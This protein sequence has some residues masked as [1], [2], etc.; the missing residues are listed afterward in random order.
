MK[1]IFGR[2][3][4]QERIGIGGYSEV[5]LAIDLQL[6]RKVVVKISKF[7]NNSKLLL[8]K[9]SFFAEASLISS[10]NHPG[11]P[12]VYDCGIEDDLLYYVMEWAQGTPMSKLKDASIEKLL[13]IFKEATK[14]ISFL[15][16]RNVI[17][18]DIKPSN[19]IILDD[20]DASTGLRVKLIDFG[21]AKTVQSSKVTDSGSIF[22]TINFMSP[23]QMQGGVI[24]MRS[25]LYSFGVTMYHALTDR[26]P[27]SDKNPTKFA[28]Q[29]LNTLPT[30]PSEYNPKAPKKLDLIVLGLLHKD[31]AERI[32]T[33]AEVSKMLSEI[34]LDEPEKANQ[35]FLIGSVP[36]VGRENEFDQ[37][38]KIW[39]LAQN[40]SQMAIISGAYGLGKSR[41]VDEFSSAIQ[42]SAETLL[43]ARGVGQ[44]GSLPL[45]GLKQILFCL[46]HF[47]FDMDV[48]SDE[49][50][51]AVGNIEP[52]YAKSQGYVSPLTTVTVREMTAA[53][54]KLL[55]L[56][57]QRR[58]ITIVLEDASNIDEV[59]LNACLELAADLNNKIF[60]IIT[61]DR[62]PIKNT[63]TFENAYLNVLHKHHIQLEPLSIDSIRRL[64]SHVCQNND[65]PAELC[66]DLT[67]KYNGNPYLILH[68]LQKLTREGNL[69]Y[70]N[71]KISY[72]KSI[73]S[74][75]NVFF[76]EI[77]SGLSEQAIRL[78]NFAATISIPFD[79]N[80]AIDVLNFPKTLAVSALNELVSASMLKSVIVEDGLQKYSVS[81]PLV[82]KKVESTIDDNEKIWLHQ[83]IAKKLENL[84]KKEHG[85]VENVALHYVLAGDL[86]KAI[87]WS[88]K[89][90]IEL[91]K[92]GNENREKYVSYIQEQAK[93]LG[94]SSIGNIADYLRSTQLLY[95]N[96]ISEAH[97]LCQKVIQ[98]SQELNDFE[99]YYDAVLVL[100]GICKKM[101]KYESFL[102]IAKEVVNK[103]ELT[104]FPDKHYEL[105]VLLSSPA[106]RLKDHPDSQKW[107]KTAL[108]FRKS[109]G[110]NEM[111][112]VD[113]MLLV[114][115]ITCSRI[116]EASKFGAEIL[117]TLAASQ[118]TELYS[119]VSIFLAYC[120]YHFGHS[121]NFI[122]TATKH[123]PLIQKPE[124]AVLKILCFS[125]AF[126]V[127]R[128]SGDF[129]FIEKNK[130]EFI[131]LSKAHPNEQSS[132]YGQASLLFAFMFKN[133]WKDVYLEISTF[134]VQNESSDLI[135]R[136]YSKLLFG[137]VLWRQ[138]R[139]RDACN[140]FAK[141][142]EYANST[143]LEVMIN[144]CGQNILS[145]L[146]PGRKYPLLDPILAYFASADVNVSN[147]YVNDL[148]FTYAKGL[149][150]LHKNGKN[151]A[152]FE[153]MM[154]LLN[155]ALEMAIGNEM[156]ALYASICLSLTYA[157][158]QRR[159]SKYASADD[160][161]K[162]QNMLFTA[163][164][165]YNATGADYMAS[166]VQNTKSEF[167]LD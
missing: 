140:L 129:D 119:V 141:A 99:T 163:E 62:A 50:L 4:L 31:P 47:D 142:W 43:R 113:V 123:L 35:V 167:V 18:R 124:N 2:Y 61:T 125:Y 112:S 144:Y 137:A 58:V 133:G 87:E 5:F 49:L 72:S 22:G 64:L 41:F 153:L 23:E 19:F 165:I 114:N 100:F 24:D 48:K 136:I 29:L 75:S 148:Y 74:G 76:S 55:S 109:R 101:E 84:A 146:V 88:K 7:Q 135:S 26:L 103:Q 164:F 147:Y 118:N 6:D 71:G 53:F 36:M 63:S 12:K 131:E 138:E 39:K 1:T 89:A 14:I 21:L 59:S 67:D 122:T 54:I 105:L 15:Q 73:T 82:T 143:G 115:L 25:D 80:L 37:L 33:G 83:T 102:S 77:L 162:A 154:K 149:V 159:H 40:S 104:L 56:L 65:F 116:Q 139:T 44:T 130:A 20:L 52:K 110:I 91:I 86:K 85:L 93:K 27:F 69:F 108:D 70:K 145:L 51:N 120:E 106:L 45:E 132:I 90:F 160:G 161:E 30:P 97:E 32:Q 38:H 92:S 9:E 81:Y 60:L 111:A 128:H 121:Q 42:L 66:A 166:V 17:H 13:A 78:L 127:A 117:K 157:H 152:E 151:M 11:I 158:Q 134:H 126:A 34:N 10:L 107:V 150:L 96:E 8:E 28:Y 68:H 94:D 155:Q 79:L 95:N 16:S 98:S 57:S 156:K 3:Q 46:S